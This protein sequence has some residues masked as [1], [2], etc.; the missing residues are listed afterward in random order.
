MMHSGFRIFRCRPHRLLRLLVNSAYLFAIL[1]LIF[2]INSRSF[3]NNLQQIP[4]NNNFD[5]RKAVI[6]VL[7]LFCDRATVTRT[8]DQLVKYRP[9]PKTFPIV[10]SQDCGL[11]GNKIKKMLRAKYDRKVTAFISVRKQLQN[12]KTILFHNFPINQ[13]Y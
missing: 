4:N 1:C 9:S 3:S 2:F 6:G 13:M 8:L 10:V 12:C 5:N 11:R 7:V